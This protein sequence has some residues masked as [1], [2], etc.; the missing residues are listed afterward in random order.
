MK[1]IITKSNKIFWHKLYQKELINQD[2]LHQNQV[3]KTKRR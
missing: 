3:Q 2:K 1:Y